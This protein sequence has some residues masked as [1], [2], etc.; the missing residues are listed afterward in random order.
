[1]FLIR[2]VQIEK[3]QR[4][5]KH[6]AAFLLTR[7]VLNNIKQI[8][9]HYSSQQNNYNGLFQCL[10]QY[11]Y[12]KCSSASSFFHACLMSIESAMSDT[13]LKKSDVYLKTEVNRQV[14]YCM[15]Y[16]TYLTTSCCIYLREFIILFVLKI[17]SFP[18]A[19]H[20]VYVSTYSS[21][22]TKNK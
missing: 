2:R 21:R 15:V 3:C 17:M 18:R 14:L 8:Y 20:S 16:R 6:A 4:A 12:E 11:N 9:L 13:A 22:D 19:A 1:M 10:Q 5:K 7:Q